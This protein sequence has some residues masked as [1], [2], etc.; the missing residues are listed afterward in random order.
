MC[1]LTGGIGG[2]GESKKE[3]PPIQQASEERNNGESISYPAQESKRWDNRVTSIAPMRCNWFGNERGGVGGQS[4]YVHS[5]QIIKDQESVPTGM[6]R[7]GLG[8]GQ[9]MGRGKK[10]FQ[11]GKRT[12]LIFHKGNCGGAEGKCQKRTGWASSR[13]IDKT[14][15]RPSKGS[16]KRKNMAKDYGKGRKRCT[17]VVSDYG[18]CKKK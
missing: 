5:K 6:P 2:K 15:R 11:I 7:V 1:T 3:Q 8:E 4:F 10:C 14:A 12:P 17:V 18:G 13:V 9:S 16:V